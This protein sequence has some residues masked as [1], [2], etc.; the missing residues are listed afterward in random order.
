MKKIVLVFIFI[1]TI[2]VANA[3][4]NIPN[5]PPPG[6]GGD[7]FE[8]YN[9]ITQSSNDLARQRLELQQLEEQNQYYAQV[10]NEKLLLLKQ[11]R[12]LIE[13]QMEAMRQKQSRTV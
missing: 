2:S 13:M 1:T 10:E 7:A 5:I 8:A 4:L 3:Q 9:R 11:Q 6:P 12:K